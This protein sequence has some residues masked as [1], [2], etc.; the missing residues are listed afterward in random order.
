MFSNPMHHV[1]PYTHPDLEVSETADHKFFYQIDLDEVNDSIKIADTTYKLL[2]HHISVYEKYGKDAI[3]SPI[4]YTATAVFRKKGKKFLIEIHIYFDEGGTQLECLVSMKHAVGKTYIPLSDDDK[5]E[6]EKLAERHARK[7]LDQLSAKLINLQDTINVDKDTKLKELT[8]ESKYG[9]A[10]EKYVHMLESTISTLQ[11]YETFIFD[12]D[13]SIK[14]CL[15]E[16]FNY[17]QEKLVRTNSIRTKKIVFLETKDEVEDDLPALASE[18][19]SEPK[20]VTQIELKEA[21][22]LMDKCQKMSIELKK[23][24]R[25]LELRLSACAVDDFDNADKIINQID[26][27]KQQ[28]VAI[29]TQACIDGN[30]VIFKKHIHDIN[31]LPNL[32]SRS[33]LST[34]VYHDRQELFD[35]IYNKIS[36]YARHQSYALPNVSLETLYTRDIASLLELAYER[37][38]IVF[39][40]KLLN[41]YHY[42]PNVVQ[43]SLLMR[44][45]MHAEKLPYLKLLLIAKVDPNKVTEMDPAG[46]RAENASSEKIK[47]DLQK[48]HAYRMSILCGRLPLHYASLFTNVEGV[49]LLLLYGAESKERDDDQYTPFGYAL[50][51]KKLSLDGGVRE[52]TFNRQLVETFLEN[53]RHDIDERQTSNSQTGL[54]IACLK[55]QWDIAQTLLDLKADPGAEHTLIVEGKP[56]QFATPLLLA[57]FKKSPIADM[58]I[59]C[60]RERSQLQ[61]AYQTYLNLKEPVPKNLKKAYLAAVRACKNDAVGFQRTGKLTEAEA[62]YKEMLT[63]E[64]NPI[65]THVIYFNLATCLH[66]AGKKDEAITHM[67][68]CVKIRQALLIKL[69]NNPVHQ[70]KNIEESI[71]T[72]QNKLAEF[73]GKEIKKQTLP[74]NIHTPAS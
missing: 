12:P 31:L 56:P 54:F 37:E 70:I 21:P 42:D 46:L 13:R 15:M 51:P 48:D 5:I 63:V 10:T 16:R 38:N 65:E 47:S 49:K 72:A 2:K 35:Y 43:A 64:T 44:A 66:R 3:V 73:E 27:L 28:E 74:I 57:L 23:I 50:V 18:S 69:S 55:N 36:Y 9:T 29:V 4:H 17:L 14:K 1:V 61:Y 67:K 22:V 24:R 20:K 11:E 34:C 58:F 7:I 45:A 25:E 60:T 8:E 40:E 62:L 32:V 59:A 41:K 68:E 26:A 71:L 6:L 30:M 33:L 19:M 39:F 53:K 52:T